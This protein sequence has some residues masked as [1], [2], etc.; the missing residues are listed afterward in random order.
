MRSVRNLLRRR[1]VR[2]RELPVTPKKAEGTLLARVRPKTVLVEERYAVRQ[3]VSRNPDSA[4]ENGASGTIRIEVPYDGHHYVTRAAL[5]DARRWLADHPH[6]STVQG[7][8]GHLVVTGHR[9][10]DLENVTGQAGRTVALPLRMPFRSEELPCDTALA[11]DRFTF[12]QEICYQPAPGRPKVVP[13]KLDIEVDDPGTISGQ[14]IH[15]DGDDISNWQQPVAFHRYLE[16]D[17]QV[18]VY[19]AG[20]KGWNPPSPCVRRMRLSP[21]PGLSLA[22]SAVQVAYR[23]SPK[24]EDEPRLVHQDAAGTGLEWFDIPTTLVAVPKD[25]SP[26]HYHTPRM[27]VRIHQPGELFSSAPASWS[28]TARSRPTARSCR[29]RTSVSSM[30]SA[31]RCAVRATRSRCGP[32]SRHRPSSSS[33]MHSRN[34]CS[35]RSRP[36][37]STR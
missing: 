34:G 11:A 31:S 16:L 10:T 32:S 12:R 25:D 13:V 6:P 8:I 18:R 5:D 36:S 4:L 9:D 30:P 24:S 19:I 20:R 1:R 3:E 2:S 22:L 21:P 33:T 15:A 28:S 26:R 17:I 7:R 27:R 14:Q 23:K 29:A 37:T 35:S